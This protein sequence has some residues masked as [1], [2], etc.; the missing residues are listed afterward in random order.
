MSEE[1]WEVPTSWAWASIG[2]IANVVGGGTPSTGD[3]NN[4]VEHGIPWLT[5]ADLT[6]YRDVYISRGRRDLSE[7]GYRTSAA[8]I[9]PAGTVLF[10]SRAPVGYCAI[11]GGEIST[12]QGFKSFVLKN[13]LSPEY[14]RHYLLASV[15]YAESKASGTTF[16][17]LSGSRAAELAVPVAPI[18]EQTRI[19]TKIDSL[20]GKSRRARDHLDHIPR[21][22]EKYKQA[23]LAAAFTGDLTREWREEGPLTY[24]DRGID[25]RLMNLG[26]LPV[27]WSWTSMGAV[28]QIGG[29]LTKNASR[30]S[31]ALRV[32]YLR[33]ANVYAN[34]LRLDEITEIG[35]T[36][37][38]YQRTLLQPGDLLIVEGNGSLDQ[39]GRVALWKGERPG[40]T[41]QNHLI[42]ARMGDDVIPPYTLFWLLSPQGRN[43]IEAVASSSSGLHTLSVSKVSGLPIPICSKEQQEEI[44]RRIEVAF[45][46][47][48]RL[49]THTASARRL[50]DHLDQSVL[51]KAFRGELVPQDPTDE[52][53]SVLLD[54]IRAGRD[55]A[56]RGRRGPRGR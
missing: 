44:V 3:D 9:V 26:V 39:I 54:R 42:R 21:L 36:E 10:S 14:T 24:D 7:R 32:P 48:D 46:W 34:E 50:I 51:T 55:V 13:G 19:V 23:V 37:G 2:E 22:V 38:E 27:G 1:R 41:H 43:S 28:A 31:L 49:A 8:R 47:I 40:C 20:T 5:P 11:A 56:P 15:D 52:P 25:R 30:S 17:E 29:G 35:C 45:K 16:K 53:A 4:F 12:N 18:P 33:V 6:G